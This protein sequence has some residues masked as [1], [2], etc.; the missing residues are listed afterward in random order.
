MAKRRLH[1][2]GDWINLRTS[3]ELAHWRHR[4][5]GARFGL[6]RAHVIL[7]RTEHGNMVAMVPGRCIG[8]PYYM[9]LCFGRYIAVTPEQAVELM[10]TTGATKKAEKLFPELASRWQP[11]K[12]PGR[13]V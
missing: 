3:T 4:P 5:G 9:M 6:L 13:A 12:P 1:N 11:T 7:Y 2:S 10:C 8:I